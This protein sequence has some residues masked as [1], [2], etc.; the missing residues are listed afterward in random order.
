VNPY[1]SMAFPTPKQ[2]LLRF[3]LHAKKS[4]G[5]NFLADAQ[6]VDRIAALAGDTP[7]EVVEIGAGLGG[8]TYSLLM[9]GHQV[10]A[11]ERD[12]DMIPVLQELLAEAIESGQ[13]RVLEADAKQVQLS[14]LFTPG[15][16]RILMGNLP[17]QITG[18]LLEN[19]VHSRAEFDRA[20]FLVQ[21]EVAERL[22]A[23]PGGKTYGALSVFCQAAFK[24]Q[25][26]F[27]VRR[28]AFYPQPNV[29]SAVVTLDVHASP[30][31]EETEAF[32]ALV[33][34]AFRERR[35]T[36][37]NAWQGVLGLSREAVQAT[38][39][40]AGVSLDARGE[41]LSVEDF[42]RMT[43]ELQRGQGSSGTS[44]D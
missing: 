36:L 3:A 30:R 37:R 20:V 42:W 38:A 43:Q 24:I 25:R 15:K 29:D 12:R 34:G 33:R 31:A 9:R 5:Q 35:K 6:L 4:F 14:E 18:P 39:D 2:T 21:K 27:L 41:T 8:L 16:R 26:A 23:P 17:Y 32:R 11:I 13:L 40:A 10:T 19:S 44:H 1:P 22:T 28:G 7:A